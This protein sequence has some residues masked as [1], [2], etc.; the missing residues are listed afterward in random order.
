VWPCWSGRGLGVGV[1]LGGGLW[2]L[3]S[4]SQAQWLLLFLL[5][6]D[7]VI[8]VLSSYSSTMSAC[9]LPDVLP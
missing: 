3:R 2:D 7:P 5:P 8:E 9:L 1:S 6:V 4:Q